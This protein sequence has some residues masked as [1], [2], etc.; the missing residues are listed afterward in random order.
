MLTIRDDQILALQQAAFLRWLEVHVSDYFPAV[1][2]QTDIQ[3]RRQTIRDGVRRAN[4]Y[5]FAAPDQ[6][7]QFVDLL[8]A[9][10]P[11][12]DRDDRLPW[13]RDILTDPEITEPAVRID[14]LFDAAREGFPP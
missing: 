10:H 3:T 12:F 1:C 6:V 8:F 2:A 9:F 7:C 4:E 14:L 13:A 11:E 5:G